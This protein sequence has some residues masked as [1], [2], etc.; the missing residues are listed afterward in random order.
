MSKPDSLLGETIEKYTRQMLE[1]MVGYSLDSFTDEQVK[2]M[3]QHVVE[4]WNSR[5]GCLECGRP[6]EDE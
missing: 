6:Y 2:Q 4:N 1:N 3:A 5:G